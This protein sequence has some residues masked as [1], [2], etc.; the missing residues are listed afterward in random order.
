MECFCRWTEK[1][2]MEN[3]CYVQLWAW[4]CFETQGQGSD[5]KKLISFRVWR[6]GTNL[7]KVLFLHFCSIA[8]LISN[9]N[10]TSSCVTKPKFMQEIKLKLYLFFC[11]FFFYLSERKFNAHGTGTLL[12][13]CID[14][15]LSTCTFEL[16]S[17]RSNPDEDFTHANLGW[18]LMSSAV[19]LFLFFSGPDYHQSCPCIWQEDLK[20]YHFLLEYGRV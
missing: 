13:R 2:H 20:G 17:G 3:R 19:F 10:T 1:I 5:S 11:C 6:G 8:V 16:C 4:L 12:C 7:F 18:H 14:C 15:S 9:F